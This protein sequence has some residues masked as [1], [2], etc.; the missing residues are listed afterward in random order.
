MDRINLLNNGEKAVAGGGLLMLIAG[1]FL[2]WWR[3]SISGFGSA[4]E[5]GFGQPGEI[6]SILAILISMALAGSI[7]AVKLG[8]VQLP[9]LPSNLSWG[10]VY[11]GGGSLSSA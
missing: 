6:W 2:P 11:G 5:G 8:N 1:L 9:A 10:Q 7:I 4:T 3:L